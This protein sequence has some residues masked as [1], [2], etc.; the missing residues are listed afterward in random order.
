MN[1]GTLAL[2]PQVVDAVNVPVVAAGGIMD[3][4]G[5]VAA[6]ALGAEGIQ[7]GTRFL[8][9]IES[10]AHPAYQEALFSANETSTKLTK[11]FSGRPARGISNTFVKRFETSR[12]DPLPFPSQNT[13]T[14]DIRAA[15]KKEGD[16]DYMSLWGGQ[17][18]RLLKK[19]SVSDILD[20]TMVIAK[21]TIG[22]RFKI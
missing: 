12:I 17:G 13:V 1:V 11:V 14:Q 18:L 5:L 10:S 6:I 15:A 8:A 9:A 21:K 2:I 22:E 7:M 20:E 19:Q 16:A 4:R 3:G